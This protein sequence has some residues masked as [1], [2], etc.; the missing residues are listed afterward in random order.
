MKNLFLKIPAILLVVALAAS[1]NK[2]QP[3]LGVNVENDLLPTVA[4]MVDL[5]NEAYLSEISIDADENRAFQAENDGLIDAYTATSADFDV[6]TGNNSFIRCLVSVNLDDDQSSQ[7][8][9]ALKAYEQRNERIIQHHRQAY[10]QLNARA[11]NAR[12]MYVAQFQ[13][14][15]IDR[16]ELAR[17][18]NM[19]REQYQKAL[20]EL[21]ASNADSLSRSFRFLMT[22]L[23]E[24]LTERQWAA[25]TACLRG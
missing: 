17:K 16:A 22:N 1:C 21:K 14:G 23:N 18:L 19:L 11:N 15:E 13:A 24:I 8:R 10:R 20:R 6:K 5:V 2:E 12:Q 9:R 4:E 7:A 3:E 25:F